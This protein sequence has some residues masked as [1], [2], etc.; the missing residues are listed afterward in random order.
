MQGVER[1]RVFDDKFVSN[2]VQ[3]Q[4]AHIASEQICT[5]VYQ[6]P[7]CATGAYNMHTGNIHS[8]AEMGTDAAG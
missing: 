3:T 1:S 6:H 5:V 8:R 4:T 2:R 7:N